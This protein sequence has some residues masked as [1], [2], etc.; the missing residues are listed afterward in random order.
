MSMGHRQKS[1]LP[2]G[3]AHDELAPGPGHRFYETRNELLRAASFDRHAEALCAPD[4]EAAPVPGRKAVA[5]GVYVRMPLVGV[6]EGIAAERGREWRFAD[7]LSLG[8]CL[9]CSLTQRV[10]D[11]STLRRTRQRL[12]LAVH[13]AVVALI[14]GI[15]ERKGLLKGRVLGVDSTS[16]RADASS[17]ACSSTSRSVA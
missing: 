1:Q 4:D 11:H 16:R 17:R 2:L 14:L 13:Q 6:F 12:P 10:P 8:Q 9:G 7:S 3:I 5:P 15:V